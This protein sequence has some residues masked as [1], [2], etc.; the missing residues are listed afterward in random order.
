M[1]D[2][3][4][5]RQGQ[6]DAA[7]AALAAPRFFAA[8]EVLENMG[9]VF[10]RNAVSRIGDRNDDVLFSF[11]DGPLRSEGNRIAPV[12]IADGVVPNILDD[13]ADLNIADGN[14]A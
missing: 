3:E 2:D 13:L 8:V 6:P 1:A 12:D 11:L 9:Q 5:L 14:V 4:L 10:G 7:A